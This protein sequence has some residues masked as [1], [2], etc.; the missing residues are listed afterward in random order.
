[1]AKLVG[2]P[3]PFPRIGSTNLLTISNCVLHA[4]FAVVTSRLTDYQVVGA[5]DSITM[6]APKPASGHAR[7]FERLM[8]ELQFE[9]LI[10][11]SDA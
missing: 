6:S 10:G 4:V 8:A 11:T 2:G 3:S 7:W 5:V 1:V 9:S